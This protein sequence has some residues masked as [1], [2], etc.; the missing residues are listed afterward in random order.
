MTDVEWTPCRECAANNA[1]GIYVAC[2]AHATDDD[3]D[4]C[5]EC[6]CYSDTYLCE[7]CTEDD[8]V[9]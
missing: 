6:G 1:A 5:A 4:A 3:D 9:D 7:S 8:D 2:V